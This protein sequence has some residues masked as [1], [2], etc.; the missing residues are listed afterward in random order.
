VTAYQR[1]GR[2]PTSAEVYR[3]LLAYSAG[4]PYPGHAVLAARLGLDKKKVYAVVRR[5][6]VLHEWATATCTPPPDPDVEFRRKVEQATPEER[7]RL[8]ADAR[9]R[10]WW[11]DPGE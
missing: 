8:F 3:R 11:Y 1:L 6:P 10:R 2:A 7:A 9:R 4:R 5:W